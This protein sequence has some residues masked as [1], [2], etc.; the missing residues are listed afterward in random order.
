[1]RT[2]TESDLEWPLPHNLDAER[3]VRDGLPSLK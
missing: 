2:A 1:M 3:I